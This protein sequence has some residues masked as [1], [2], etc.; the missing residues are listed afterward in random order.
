MEEVDTASEVAAKVIE[1]PTALEVDPNKHERLYKAAL[2]QSNSGVTYR[3][4]AKV[5]STGTVDIVHYGCDMDADG[6][7]TMKRK[8]R[9]ILEQAPERFDKE[10]QAI[11][12]RVT[13]D[14]QVRQGAWLADMTRR[15]D[16]PAEGNR[17]GDWSRS[18]IAGV[19]KR[20]R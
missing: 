6:K 19:R 17:L 16:H 7:P 15:P 4:L 1:D 8:I 10:F 14:D 5:L 3:M 2:V 11:R 20:P 9:R 12:K 13:D 18:M